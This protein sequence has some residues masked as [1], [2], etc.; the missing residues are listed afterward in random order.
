MKVYKVNLTEYEKGWGSKVFDTLYFKKEEKA[1][2]YIKE[3]NAKK[4][5]FLQIEVKKFFE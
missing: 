5:P 2:S 3:Y 4:T 1:L